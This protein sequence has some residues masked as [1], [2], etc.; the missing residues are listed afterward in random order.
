MTPESS[1]YEAM[2]AERNG[3]RAEI[4]M[5]CSLAAQQEKIADLRAAEIERLL[6][7]IRKALEMCDPRET[8]S[9]H[10]GR[11]L[12]AALEPKP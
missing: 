12:Q 1:E 4:D 9:F 5:L 11:V 8:R 3:L 10:I 6:A 7:I 2:I